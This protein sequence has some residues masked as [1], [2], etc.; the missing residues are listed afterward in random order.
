MGVMVDDSETSLDPRRK[1]SADRSIPQAP[2]TLNA[3][4][5]RPRPGSPPAEHPLLDIADVDDEDQTILGMEAVPRPSLE[6]D[7]DED[8]F[9]DETVVA[10][11]VSKSPEPWRQVA[12]AAEGPA[13]RRFEEDEPTNV[14]RTTRKP[15]PRAETD[16]A[17]DEL[18]SW[19]ENRKRSRSGIGSTAAAPDSVK[20]SLPS[21]PSGSSRSE[22][23]RSPTEPEIE[24]QPT[25]T[26][27]DAN[28]ATTRRLEDRHRAPTRVPGDDLFALGATIEEAPRNPTMRDGGVESTRRLPVQH[29]EDRAAQRSNTDAEATLGV[30]GGARPS[31]APN[32]AE[33]NRRAPHA[34]SARPAPAGASPDASANLEAGRARGG[35]KAS[36][37]DT[38]ATEDARAER[39]GASHGTVPA[40]R[41]GASANDE[42][43]RAGASN[44]DD[45]RA[46]RAGAAPV[47]RGGALA[48]ADAH[49]AG[50]HRAEAAPV[51]RGGA[52]ASVDAHRAGGSPA[53][54]RAHRAEAAPVNRGGASASVD[55]HRAGGS[56]ADAHAYRSEPSPDDGRPG[57]AAASPN[58][59]RG[60]GRGAA[61]DPR[62][63]GSA[64][65]ITTGDVTPDLTEGLLDPPSI[66]GAPQPAYD[67]PSVHG[68]PHRAFT[69]G[70]A[71]PAPAIPDPPPPREPRGITRSI[72]T[73]R[74]ELA[75]VVPVD[76]GEEPSAES[77]YLGN[78]ADPGDDLLAAMPVMYG[79]ASGASGPSE[80]IAAPG[81][82]A[83]AA[84]PR[85]LSGLVKDLADDD[86]TVSP[87]LQT[88]S[89]VR[90]GL[91]MP[92]GAHERPPE[93]RRGRESPNAPKKGGH[94]TK[95]VLD[96]P[97]DFINE[98]TA[99]LLDR[100][101]I[102]PDRPGFDDDRSTGDM[103]PGPTGEAVAFLDPAQL[104]VDPRAHTAGVQ[105]TGDV[106]LSLP[107]SGRRIAAVL[108]DAI[109]LLAIVVAPTVL[110][111]FG[112]GIT[113]AA[114]LDPDDTSALLVGGHFTL[115][116]V[117]GIV[118]YLV[119]SGL[120][121]T[122]GGRTLGKLA[123]GLELVRT[124]TGERIGPLRAFVRAF[125]GLFGLLLGGLGYFWLLV[126]RR[127]RTLHDHLSRTTV[128]RTR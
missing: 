11:V 51:N 12:Q 9:G 73:D 88:N 60:G 56:P 95:P 25:F 48:N 17:L 40:K 76:L 3:P 106:L 96:V 68:V 46:P 126:D 84:K 36:P 100:L 123:L 15:R 26:D 114:L 70:P 93:R 72:A 128:V 74:K 108:V 30:A 1:G 59:P 57:R 103:R 119:Y 63:G 91:D 104:V 85:S 38:S 42:G 22:A 99:A 122:F 10:P 66:H 31:A 28:P 98:E 110:G 83:G 71:D 105:P 64:G 87:V 102:P 8:M 65:E 52:S 61:N 116:I 7:T 111:V 67:P 124:K 2:S 79:Q 62:F 80:T 21:F 77:T 86:A 19:A 29:G 23:R 24:E 94:D 16:A 78:L 18:R 55:G 97:A 90:R 121:H 5:R 54:A 6:E 81:E 53:D 13:K 33:A 47:N 49:R 20:R 89:E 125:V 117:A 4:S 107:S 44:A 43:H 58:S 82:L 120:A 101:D 115:P 35:A 127:G 32:A 109:L 34:P 39:A 69:M 37:A 41:A 14:P 27:D 45:V 113:K 92:L 112:D 50:A 118:L 75:P